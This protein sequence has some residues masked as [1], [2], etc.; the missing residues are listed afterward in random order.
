MDNINLSRFTINIIKKST[1]N[2]RVFILFWLDTKIQWL[3]QIACDCNY[4]RSVPWWNLKLHAAT[5]NWMDGRIR[6]TKFF[7]I[8]QYYFQT[9]TIASI[10]QSDS[11]GVSQSHCR[12]VNWNYCSQ[13]QLNVFN[14]NLPFPQRLARHTYRTR[15]TCFRDNER[16]EISIIICKERSRG[17]KRVETKEL[18]FEW[19]W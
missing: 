7:S 2:G 8:I 19:L 10:H 1:T 13:I 9:L 14:F 11:A 3:C 18:A 15:L 16:P 12:F 5:N 6:Q 17:E 4:K